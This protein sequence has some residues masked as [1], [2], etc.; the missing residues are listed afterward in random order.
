MFVLMVFIMDVAVLVLHRLVFMFVFVPLRKVQPDANTHERSR[1]AKENGK[2]F[3]KDHQG[4][5]GTNEGG[6]REICA[7]PSRAY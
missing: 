1:H 7:S 6:E 4:E 3:L 5:C 2:S